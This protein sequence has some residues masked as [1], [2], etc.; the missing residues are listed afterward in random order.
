MIDLIPKNNKLIERSLSILI[1]ELSIDKKQ[2]KDLYA[3][4]HQNLKVAI[5][6]GKKNLSYIQACKALDDSEGNLKQILK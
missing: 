1:N 4:S 3:S 5:I 6:M 2:A